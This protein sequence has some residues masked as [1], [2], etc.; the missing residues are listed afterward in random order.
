MFLDLDILMDYKLEKFRKFS[1]D[2]GDLVVFLKNSELSANKKKFG[3]IYFVSFNSKGVVR[4]NHYHKRWCEW[5]G[6]VAGKVELVLEDVITKE[7]V[8]LQFDHADDEY[9]R[10]YIGPN[11]AHAFRSISPYAALLN[12]ADSEWYADDTHP[13]KLL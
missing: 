10:L 6:V 12:Y 4:G 5:F 3:Q 2:R 8:D 13:Y 9:T 1:D 11:I 7:R